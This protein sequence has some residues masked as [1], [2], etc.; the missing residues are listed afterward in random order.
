M[1]RIAQ[2]L[3]KTPGRE[4][5]ALRQFAVTPAA[6]KRL[7]AKALA[8]HPTLRTALGSATVVIVAGTTNGYVAEEILATLG[9]GAEFSRRRF[10][11]GI[12]LPPARPT[13][14]LGRL[15]DESEFPGDVIIR[16][17]AWIRGKTLFDVVDELRE[18]DVIVKGANALDVNSRHAGVLIGHP[19]AGILGAALQ[20]AAGRRVRLILPVGLEK[21]IPGDLDRLALRLN[22]PGAHGPRFL[23]SPGEVFTEIEAIAMLTGASAEIAAAGG[24]GGAEGCVW[25]AVSGAPAQV[26]KAAKLIRSVAAEPPFR[27]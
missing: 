10:F 9:K 24:V 19:K 13:T 2:R 12:I 21:R 4:S 25:L 18:G 11:R 7:I 17:G 26:E 14:E 3:I 1:K 8:V 16:R 5:I 22:A 23:A 20:A 6:G 15:P 27:I